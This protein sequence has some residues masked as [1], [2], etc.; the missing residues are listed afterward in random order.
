M[1]DMST[2]AFHCHHS[3]LV[4]DNMAPTR[5]PPVGGGAKAALPP[6]FAL[7]DNLSKA[8]IKK[9]IRALKDYCC[10]RSGAAI[11]NHEQARPSKFARFL[12][13]TS[14]QNGSYKILRDPKPGYVDLTEPQ[15]HHLACYVMNF[16]DLKNK[17]PH[18]K[19]LR[20]APR[21]FRKLR[22]FRQARNAAAAPPPGAAAPAPG[23]A[24]PPPGAAPPPP[25][26]ITPAA[27]HQQR[28]NKPSCAE[29]STSSFKDLYIQRL[30]HAKQTYK[31]DSELDD[32]VFDNTATAGEKPFMDNT[33]EEYRILR[34][35]FELYRKGANDLRCMNSTAE[36]LTA[37]QQGRIVED[38]WRE[39]SSDEAEE[40]ESEEEAQ[41]QE[42]PF[43]AAAAA[44]GPSASAKQQK[45]RKRTQV[46]VQVQAKP[47]PPR[48]E[49][50]FPSA[51][52]IRKSINRDLANHFIPYQLPI[53]K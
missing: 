36:L 22:E 44:A 26:R 41:V 11:G 8:Q 6:N 46:Q 14:N 3:F 52:W 34:G 38:A 17:Q 39:L 35:C 13:V 19:N 33:A 7:F 28:P 42:K 16:D 1:V 29:F 50:H 4:V 5:K 51:E 43:R 53:R 24:A 10:P 37:F 32:F 15:L 9:A 23:A 40:V 18:L 27:L 47:P 21:F 31:E 20:H 48:V 25:R 49:L 30:E 45:K 12:G 2:A